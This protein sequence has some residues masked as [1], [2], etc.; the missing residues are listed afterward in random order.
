MLNQSTEFS[1]DTRKHFVGK[2]KFSFDDFNNFFE[3]AGLDIETSVLLNRK[4]FSPFWLFLSCP[5]RLVPFQ[6]CDGV[7]AP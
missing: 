1:S 6:P 5:T 3:R 2:Q 4:K 7:F